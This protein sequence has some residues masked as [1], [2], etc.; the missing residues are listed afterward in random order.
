M[1]FIHSYQNFIDTS[2][3][4]QEIGND[5]NLKVV[6]MASVDVKKVRPYKMKD[7]VSNIMGKK[8]GETISENGDDIVKDMINEKKT[9]MMQILQ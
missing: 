4:F 1:G 8:N 6:T 3:T 2:E 7:N 5:Q 9:I